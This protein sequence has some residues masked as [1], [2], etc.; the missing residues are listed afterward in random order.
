MK[1]FP[2]K[3]LGPD[4]PKLKPQTLEFFIGKGSQFSF[5]LLAWHESDC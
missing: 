5:S 1:R 3:S 4:Y 2:A